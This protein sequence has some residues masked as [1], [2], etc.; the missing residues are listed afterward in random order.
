MLI[1]LGGERTI[2]SV[3]AAR[4]VRAELLAMAAAAAT[5]PDRIQVLRLVHPRLSETRLEAEW[6]AAAGAF[7][8][9]VM[10]RLSLHV[11]FPDGRVRVFG[12]SASGD[13]DAPDADAGG[14]GHRLPRRDLDFFV[15]K[16]LVWAWLTGRGPLTRKWLELA[17]GC[18]YPTVAAVVR[19]LG[20]A[21]A[22][23]H[24]RRIHLRHLPREE[25]ARLFATATDARS[26]LRFADAS[27]QPSTATDLLRRVTRIAPA[28]IAI[29]GV[30]AA[31]RYF[32]ALDVAGLPR[33]DV[34]V[35][36][37][38]RDADLSFVRRLD[39]ALR[40]VTDRS[41]PAVLALHFVRHHDPLFVKRPGDLPLADPVESL[42]DLH[43][44]G[45]ETQAVQFL[46]ALQA[47]A[48]GTP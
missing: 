6:V 23:H 21:V 33:L 13:V 1:M 22:R 7:R 4:I 34:S 37:P 24:D 48:S 47:E 44:A 20:S 16:L 46:D 8:P 43:E 39:P 15:E 14:G 19:R 3:S 40:P 28:G 18:S 2:R 36:A 10:D 27:D 17:A 30:A 9:E 11:R 29:G 38:A 5:N 26:T 12:T 35:H 32:P 42:L 41:D 31:G 25:W 45:L